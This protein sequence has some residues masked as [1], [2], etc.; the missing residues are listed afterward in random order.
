[1]STTGREESTDAIVEIR[2]LLERE[3]V[4]EAR[5]TLQDALA[6]HPNDKELLRLQAI[7]APPDVRTSGTLDVDR[8]KDFQWLSDNAAQHRGRWVAIHDGALV[9]EA[10][11]LDAL[12]EQVAA[13]A[14]TDTPLIH[15]ID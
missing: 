11:S 5:S 10:T 13:R 6:S 12:L 8:T 1:M 7:L 15:F 4:S 2:D 14:L 9:G 3:R